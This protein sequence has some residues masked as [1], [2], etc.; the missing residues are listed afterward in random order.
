MSRKDEVL[1]MQIMLMPA[2]SKA[3]NVTYPQLS[4]I[5]RQYDVL[6]YIDD[7]YEVFNSYGESGI[8]EDITDYVREQGG[9]VR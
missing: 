5:V 6:G 8:V 4:N 9:K 2:L 3:W 1:D 7:A